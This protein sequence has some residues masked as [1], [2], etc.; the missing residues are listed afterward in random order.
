MK[1]ATGLR[2]WDFLKVAL[3]RL[4]AARA[5]AEILRLTLEAQYVGGYAIECSLKALI[6]QKT[7]ERDRPSRRRA[8]DPWRNVSSP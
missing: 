8:A 6:L 2:G 3:Q 1:I 4:A 7:A 5:I